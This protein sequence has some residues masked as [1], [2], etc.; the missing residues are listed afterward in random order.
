MF[1]YLFIYIYIYLLRRPLPR[2]GLGRGGAA[3]GI[4]V[5]VRLWPARTFLR[6]SSFP[7]CLVMYLQTFRT[8][9]LALWLY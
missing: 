5:G 3:P 2:L 9:R 7:R 1:I 6:H 8:C 4:T